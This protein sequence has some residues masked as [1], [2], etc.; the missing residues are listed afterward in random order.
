MRGQVSRW[1]PTAAMMLLSLLSYV[2]R[3]VLAI[4]SPTI[5]R[6]THLTATDYTLAISAFSVA[7][8]IGNPV[9]GLLLDR[10]GVRMGVSLAA[11]I[12][13][14]ASA[15]H[16]Q[17][18]GLVTF[19]LARAVLGFGEGATFPGGMRTA[20]Q[21]LEPERRAR[22]VA[23]AYSGGSLGAVLT[24]ILVAPIAARWGWRG[25]FYATGFLGVVWLIVWAIVSPRP[26]LGATSEE[27]RTPPPSLY[28]GSILGF[29]AAYAFGGFPLAFV[30]Y[31]APLYF[32]RGLGQTQTTIEHVLW[33]P[34]L[35][36]EIG[37]FFWAWI[38][39]RGARRQVSGFAGARS[40]PDGGRERFGRIFQTLALLT[41]PFAATPFVHALPAV[42]ALM[43]LQMFVSAGFVI[44]SLSEVTQRRSERHSAFLSGIAGGAWSGLVALVLPVIG[45][46]FDRSSYTATFALATL[47]PIVGWAIH[48]ALVRERPREQVAPEHPTAG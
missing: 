23:L 24:P 34:P 4:L 7:Y 9:W 11:A 30:L 35:G 26:E 3:N 15:L 36:W 20:T 19:A 6:E 17:A 32:A 14:C 33:L 28:D 21:T 2:D 40:K 44:V 27:E 31:A 46:L 18:T 5:L 47:A 37:Y 48:L 1:V 29:A 45:K 22:G 41:L 43:F 16:A 13:T 42:L 8:L 10:F 38:L 12:W 39:D 25:A